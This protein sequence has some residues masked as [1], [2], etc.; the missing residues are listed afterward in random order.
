MEIPLNP[1]DKKSRRKTPAC[2]PTRTQSEV[3]IKNINSEVKQEMKTQVTNENPEI[4][5]TNLKN[6]AE[7]K[8]KK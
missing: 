8:E 2:Y 5:I 7:K 3:G 6:T 4:P 1:D